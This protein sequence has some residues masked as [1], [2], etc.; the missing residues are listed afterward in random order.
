MGELTL[1]LQVN[2]HLG[3]VEALIA[4]KGWR[5]ATEPGVPEAVPA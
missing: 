1:F 4:W 2:R 3:L 5:N